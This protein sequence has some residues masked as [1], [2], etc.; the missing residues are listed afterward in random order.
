MNKGSILPELQ[1]ECPFSSIFKDVE[2]INGNS[3]FRRKIGHIRADYDGFRWW[4][5][6][7]HCNDNLCTPEIAKEID[8]V[9]E[10][11]LS[12]DAFFT[13][14]AMQEFCYKRLGAAVNERTR[15]EYN[16]YYT[17]KY[18]YFWI[19]CITRSGDYNLYLHAFT[20]ES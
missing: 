16:F 6:V 14:R 19:R 1:I 15:D 10:R 20:K 4:N 17:G 9:Y 18:C 7:W 11:L 2:T 12:K 5:T 3:V 8:T 13:L